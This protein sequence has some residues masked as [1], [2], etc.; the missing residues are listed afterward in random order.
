LGN[1]DIGQI[2]A[3]LFGFYRT[4]QQCMQITSLFANLVIA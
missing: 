4:N 2:G 3:S 1:I